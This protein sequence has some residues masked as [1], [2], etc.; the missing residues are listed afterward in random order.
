MEFLPMP[1][2][3]ESARTIFPNTQVADT[4]PATI[5][6]FNQL[7]DEEQ[8]ALLWLAYTEMGVTPNGT[9]KVKE[10]VVPSQLVTPRQKV[11]I[12][13]IDNPTI[14]SYMDNM[15]A[16]DFEAAVA[17]FSEDGALQ[18][19][20]GK[21]IVG[22]ENILAYMREECYGLKFIP[23]RGVSESTE[24][25]FTPIKVTGKVQTSWFSG[26]VGVN[27][28]WRFL[29]NPEG[30]IFFVVIDLLASPQKLL[31]LGLIRA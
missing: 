4:V 19:P 6:S 23:E 13:G 20:F 24:E 10:P 14:L 1:F 2:T 9:P 28:A 16:F 8:L 31:N 3:L 21:P 22:Q 29:L 26:S 25:G 5:E 15:K 30:Q 11:R 27:L 7:S 17:L 18:P 12:E